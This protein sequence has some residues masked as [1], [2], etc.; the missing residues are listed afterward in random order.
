MD[1]RIT[2]NVPTYLLVLAIIE[3]FCC[4]QVAG[5][6]SLVFFCLAED[7][8][9]KSMPAERERYIRYCKITLVLGPIL[10]LILAVLYVA[11]LVLTIM[12]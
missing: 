11:Y 2:T 5:T 4:N 6:L 1:E 7:R 3:T 8:D 10:S 12:L 9:K